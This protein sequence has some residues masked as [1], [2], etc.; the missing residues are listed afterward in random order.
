[1][2]SLPTKK[3]CESSPTKNV[4]TGLL[5]LN[6]KMVFTENSSDRQVLLIQPIGAR[7]DRAMT[8]AANTG[9]TDERIQSSISFMSKSHCLVPRTMSFQKFEMSA[10]QSSY[11]IPV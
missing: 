3:K 4:V 9:V 11:L 1:M 7:Q 2:E 5:Y 10:I 8:R 6:T